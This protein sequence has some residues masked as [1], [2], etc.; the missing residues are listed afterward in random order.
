MRMSLSR[1]AILRGAGV[2]LSLPW[3][4]A[5]A[6]TSGA[7][8]KP[9]VRFAAL[10][11]PNGVNVDAWIPKGTGRDF[12]LSPTLAPLRELK[13]RV[14]VVSNLWNANS[15]GGDGHYVKE[16]A[17]LTCTTIKKTPGADIG[18]GVSVDQ[19]AAQRV[20]SQT[21]L[22]SLE[23]GVTPVAVGVDAVVGYTRVYGSH[24]AWANSTT[25]L[26][27]E[28]NPRS[29]YERLF[30]AASGQTGDA[31]KMDTL[32][33]DRVLGDANRLRGKVS[34]AD[35]IR[36]DEYLSLMRS[37]EQR[38]QRASAGAQRTWKA[39]AEMDPGG[40]PP[41]K[42]A[43]H[44]EHVRLMMDMIAVAFQT[45]TTRV[46]TFM[47]GNAVSNVSFR[48]LEG[49]SAGHHDVSHHQKEEDK[50]RQ[51]AIIS[52]W[53]VEQYAY[54]LRRLSEMKEGESTVLD[55]SM[56]LFASALS[57][58][59]S[60]NPH[61]LPVVVGGRGGGRIDSGQHL[62]YTE[63]SPLANLYVSMLDAFGAPVER[64]ADSTGPLAGFLRGA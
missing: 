34:T 16:A 24:I 41:E 3:L 32:L 62:V 51:Y 42:P 52:R 20:G 63:D 11:M 13:D 14:T 49:V 17:I 27:R 4:E 40:K 28:I 45:D 47:F 33:L 12:E 46:A 31:A 18:N 26:A 1:R 10:Y 5:M 50:L 55:N 37:L 36:I 21:P 35:R 19:V 9:P 23:L 57:D 53:H 30:R 38:V 58:G 29:V 56:V 54:L 39:R 59:N 64:F 44:A 43:D 6:A 2:G 8:G 25:P 15:K 48:F 61:R 60:H 22:P 7:A